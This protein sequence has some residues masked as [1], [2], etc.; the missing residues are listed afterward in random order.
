MC[1]GWKSL[2]LR[3]AVYELSVD[4]V[5][6]NTLLI[7]P[8]IVNVTR[9]SVVVGIGLVDVRALYLTPQEVALPA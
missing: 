9:S 7:P 4:V 3:Q 8:S 2:A 5:E 1:Q 6:A